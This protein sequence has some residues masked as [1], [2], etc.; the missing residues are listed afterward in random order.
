MMEIKK[1]KAGTSKDTTTLSLL[2]EQ[3]RDLRDHHLPHTPYLLEV[4]TD[5][6]YRNEFPHENK[7]TPF[8]SWEVKPLQYMTL[9]QDGDRGIATARGNWE[10]EFAGPP[11]TSADAR[12]NTPTPNALR[13]TKKASVKYSIK[14]YKSMKET[15]VKPSPKPLAA[16]AD[17]KPSQ[18]KNLGLSASTPMS[19]VSSMEGG[20][21]GGKQNGANPVGR[22]AR[23]EKGAREDRTS[24]IFSSRAEARERPLHNTNGHVDSRESLQSK[25]HAQK[26]PKT[27]QHSLPP[28]KHGLP[29]RPPSPRR[30]RQPADAKK[31]PPDSAAVPAEKRTKIEPMKSMSNSL[32]NSSK[33]PE[34][35]SDTRPS[36]LKSQRP[37]A[38]ASPLPR[39]SRQNSK[40]IDTKQAS[41]SR[42]EK[43]NNLPPLLSPLPADLDNEPISQF[44]FASHVKEP[45]SGRNSSSNTPSTKSKA[46]NRDTIVVKSSANGS[47]PLSTPPD[48]SSP[49]FIL[50]PILS[51]TLPAVVEQE[52][53]RIQQKGTTSLNTVE[54]RHEK[55]RQPDAPGVARKTVKSKVGHP[56]RKQPADLS[57]KFQESERTEQISDSTPS[58]VVKLEYRMSS[59]KRIEEILRSK[60]KPGSEFRKPETKP[61]IKKPQVVYPSDSEEDVPLASLQKQAPTAR[62]RPVESVGSQPLEP[63]PKRREIETQKPNNTP[64]KPA[65]KSPAP[66]APSDKSLL[67]TPKRTEAVKTVAMRRVD[68][69]DGHARTPQAAPASTPASAEKPRI[70]GDVRPIHNSPEAE[71]LFAE[72][73]RYLDHATKLKRRMDDILKIKSKAREIVPEQQRK[74]GLCVAFEALV[75]YMQ[76][77]AYNVRHARALNRPPTTSQW[78]SCL[79]LWDFME[80]YS[81]QWVPTFAPLSSR[82]GAICREELRR[83][84]MDSRE[85]T[86]RESKIWE[87]I[88]LNDQKRDQLWARS[89]ATKGTLVELG[90]A[91]TIGPWTTIPDVTN[92]ALEFLT[93]YSKKENAGWKKEPF[94]GV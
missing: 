82:L 53:L 27:D 67:A 10:D 85:Y 88:R 7:N 20:L 77:F 22:V 28:I 16:D 18:S 89:Y 69:G 15:G 87:L 11:S 24:D 2:N 29:P 54:A 47:S 46:P 30:D 41:K 55:V 25:P 50:P 9:I 1:A 21:A 12:S 94:G 32:N 72:E 8:H 83:C 75:L 45:K 23:T 57:S 52:L 14:D 91:D 70:N 79:K 43:P 76:S 71:R 6:P 80:K 33:K 3:I 84:A 73:K 48:S 37:T 64:L 44:S 90:V 35:R 61:E 92:F 62:K 38:Q 68:S 42:S 60:P 36:P 59:R 31:R 13:E 39:K 19:R 51:P 40:P 49:P 66:S 58:Y 81:L 4:I 63:P 56:P 74:L 93:A 26:L 34:P 86:T 65:F 78:E 5:Y 17:R